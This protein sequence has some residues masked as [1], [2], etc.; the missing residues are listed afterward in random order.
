MPD[1]NLAAAPFPSLD[2]ARAAKQRLVSGGFV[3]NSIDIERQGD[4]VEVLIHVREEQRER[5]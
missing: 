1:T 3:R 5:S 2:A 4:V